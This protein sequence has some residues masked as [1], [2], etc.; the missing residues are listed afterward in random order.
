ML[1]VFKVR[2]TYDVP[3]KFVEGDGVF[4]YDAILVVYARDEE[5]VR[6]LILNWERTV[7]ISIRTIVEGGTTDDAE[8][9]MMAYNNIIGT[10]LLEK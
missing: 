9:V 6:Q 7:E 2:C 3:Y 8:I 1:K 5:H 4:M 10:R